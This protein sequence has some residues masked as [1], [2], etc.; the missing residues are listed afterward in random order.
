HPKQGRN[1]ALC[2]R[3]KHVG[4]IEVDMMRMTAQNSSGSDA[5]PRRCP[6]GILGSE[7]GF[8]LAFV[9]FLLAVCTLLGIGAMNTSVDETDITTNE[10]IV[11]KVFSLAESGLPLATIPVARTYGEGTWNADCDNPVYLSDDDPDTVD[12]ESGVIQIL[13]GDFLYEGRDFDMAYGTRWNNWN[14]YA[15]APDENHKN[16]YKPIDDPFEGTVAEKE[17][18]DVETCPDIRLR[19]PN[20][21]VIDVD[22][23]KVAVKY[24][25]GG[26]AE[27]GSGA[28]G[29]AGMSVKVSYNFN[30]RATVPGKDIDSPTAPRAETVIGWGLIPTG[31]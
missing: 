3:G 11:K 19:A 30:S 31:F 14:K 24:S 27:F 6:A 13:D 17:A 25:A 8:I 9:M 4:N 20:Q 15:H 12:D 21:L 1:I 18:A 2:Y 23:D 5:A 28:D 26:V 22:V 29:A 10:V 7:S 16:A